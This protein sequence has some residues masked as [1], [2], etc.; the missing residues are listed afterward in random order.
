VRWS[1][2]KVA[3]PPAPHLDEGRLRADVAKIS[4]P[5][6]SQNAA[7]DLAWLIRCRAGHEIELAMLS[8]GQI[9]ILHMPGELFVEYQLAAQQ[10]RSDLHVAMAA[11]GDYGP[12][13]IGTARAYDEGGYETSQRATR[14]APAVEDVLLNAM[15][16]LLGAK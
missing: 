16:K 14:V 13:Y 3:L 1:V 12:G 8:L 7:D 10:M 15:R 4:D 9:R 11:Y 2:Q 6:V 5:P